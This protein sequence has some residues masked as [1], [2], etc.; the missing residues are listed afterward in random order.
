MCSH[1]YPIKLQ[2][3]EEIEE[4]SFSVFQFKLTNV[5]KLKS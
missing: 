5:K 1:V 4:S 2:Q 3:K